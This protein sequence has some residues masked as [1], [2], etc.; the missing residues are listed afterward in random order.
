MKKLTVTR[1]RQ[2]SM[3]LAPYWVVTAMSRAEFLRQTGLTGGPSALPEDEEPE[4][5]PGANGP[6]FDP[7]RYGT[8]IKNGGTL[9]LELDD[10]AKTI[11]AVGWDGA[12]SNELRLAPGPGE[13]HIHIT[14]TGGWSAP[15]RAQLEVKREGGPAK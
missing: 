5:L 13:W 4:D 6:T 7:A 12:V 14:T 3:M 15:G 11:F 8:P 10:A 1:S 9:T 2:F